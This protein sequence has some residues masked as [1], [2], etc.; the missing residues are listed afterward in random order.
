MKALYSIGFSRIGVFISVPKRPGQIALTFTPWLAHSSASTRVRL[1]RPPLAEAYGARPAIPITDR[2]EPILITRPQPRWHILGANLR[3][4]SF[5]IPHCCTTAFHLLLSN[6]V[7]KPPDHFFLGVGRQTDERHR[8][9]T[10]SDQ[11]ISMLIGIVSG[12]FEH[13]GRDS[14]ELNLQS[15]RLKIGLYE[16]PNLLPGVA[17]GE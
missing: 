16:R 14:I 5:Q 1:R 13:F 9:A 11:E 12:I 7:A 8:E 2:I 6:A 3:A 10:Y 17:A 15:P 4:A